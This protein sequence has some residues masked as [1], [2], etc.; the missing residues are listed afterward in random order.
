VTISVH[1]LPDRRS[2]E[3]T[4]RDTG[5]GISRDVLPVIFDKFHQADNSEKRDH[6]GMGLGLYIAKKFT[7]MLRGTITVESQIGAGS[8]FTLT[9]TDH[10]TSDEDT[11]LQQSSLTPSSVGY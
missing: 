6:E 8:A 11:K 9:I 1:Y 5:M 10:T 7:E 3:F 4:V 2:V